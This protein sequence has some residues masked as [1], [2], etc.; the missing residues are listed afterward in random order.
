MS[1]E[2][3]IRNVAYCYLVNANA[4]RLQHAAKQSITVAAWIAVLHF[5]ATKMFQQ[6]AGYFLLF[7]TQNAYVPSHTVTLQAMLLWGG[8]QSES[9]SSGNKT[10]LPIEGC[11]SRKRAEVGRS[12]CTLYQMNNE[13][14]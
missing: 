8:H 14:D 6:Y 7:A 2:R 1:K 4:S 11:N 3:K 9:K 13:K 5:P 10:I 12:I